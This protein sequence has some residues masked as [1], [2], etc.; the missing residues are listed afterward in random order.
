MS[1]RAYVLPIE[2]TRWNAPL[3]G[4]FVFNWEYDEGR[5]KLLTLYEKGKNL[6]W[7][8]QNRIDWSLP[9]DLDNP[10]QAPDE[11]N[12]L[13]GTK[14]WSKL[15]EKER[16]TTRLHV[17]SWQFSNFLHGEQGALLC[18]AKIVQTVPDMDSKYYAATQVMDE[19][20]HVEVY[21]RYLNEKLGMA[22]PI[23]PDLK[24]LLDQT[25]SDS[26]WDFTYLGMQILI[27]GLALAA[28]G[29]IRD[30]AQ[31]PLA[32]ALNAYVMQD[33]ARHVAFGRFALRDFYR[34]LTEAER[35]PREEFCVE[36]CYLMRD[37]FL[38][39]EVWNNLGYGEEAIEAVKTS[40]SMRDFQTFLFSR[41][42]PA[43]REIG[44][45]GDKVRRAFEDMGVMGFAEIDLD[46]L[47]SSDEAKALEFDR[48][49]AKADAAIAEGVAIAKAAG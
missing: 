41:I 35:A 9:V 25:L 36:A 17:A 19:A 21:S 24:T 49:R 18:A 23:N 13:F 29:M 45:W 10:L 28:F 43:L 40:V 46:S 27:E 8:G 15:S 1:T 2:Q 32:G 42:V 6:Q 11:Y 48:S 5:D 4:N 26:R 39:Q 31:A 14:I 22:Y 20:R 34:E 33:E 44:L 16:G 47:S 37:R 3:G 30:F 7:N 12:P 38:A